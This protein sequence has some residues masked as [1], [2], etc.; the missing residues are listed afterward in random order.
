MRVWEWFQWVFSIFPQITGP[1]MR[2]L[3]STN[4]FFPEYNRVVQSD[5]VH[6]GRN[7]MAPNKQSEIA[8]P[9]KHCAKAINN[10]VEVVKKFNIPVNHIVEVSQYYACVL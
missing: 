9:F 4:F 2:I 6:I 3:F 7:Y 8:V 1:G 5:D 10:L